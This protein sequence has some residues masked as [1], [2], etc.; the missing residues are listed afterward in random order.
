[1]D[2]ESAGRDSESDRADFAKLWTDFCPD[3]IKIYPDQL[4]ANAELYEYWQ[5]GIPSISDKRIG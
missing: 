3:E 5:R 2:A 1:M 4:L